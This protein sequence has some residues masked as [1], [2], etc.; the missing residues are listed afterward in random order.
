M[1]DDATRAPELFEKSA[2][3]YVPY[4][5]AEVARAAAFIDNFDIN[6]IENYRMA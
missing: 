1:L 5:E 4:A 2:R 3:V 6:N